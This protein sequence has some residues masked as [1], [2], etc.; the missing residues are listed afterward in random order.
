MTEIKPCPYPGCESGEVH[1]MSQS[2]I[3]GPIRYYVRCFSCGAKGSTKYTAESA[4]EA[5]CQVARR[6]EEIKLLKKAYHKAR[7]SAAGLTNYCEESASTRRCEKE[8]EEAENL[9]RQTLKGAD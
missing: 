6:R 9:F 5:W 1:V 7:N 3:Q 2:S 8:L 4:V